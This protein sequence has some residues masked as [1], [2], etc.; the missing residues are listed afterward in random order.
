[1]PVA[2]RKTSSTALAGS[3]KEIAADSDVK[4]RSRRGSLKDGTVMKLMEPPF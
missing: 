1:M 3:F 2:A 4:K